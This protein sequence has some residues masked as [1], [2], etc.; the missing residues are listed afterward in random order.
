MPWNLK[1]TTSLSTAWNA[2][3]GTPSWPNI[4]AE[5]RTLM[6]CKIYI[7]E[8]RLFALFSTLL[9]PLYMFISK[10]FQGSLF[11]GF[12]WS[13]QTDMK[14]EPKRFREL[15][16]GTLDWVVYVF[17]DRINVDVSTK[18]NPHYYVSDRVVWILECVSGDSGLWLILCSEW[19]EKRF[20]LVSALPH[21]KSLPL[22]NRQ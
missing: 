2:P 18:T 8:S 6:L 15:S 17:N 4:W 20:V 16:H 10:V 12:L 1:H 7:Y 9:P 13:T 19:K 21:K 5:Q 22:D 14:R 11:R 3:H